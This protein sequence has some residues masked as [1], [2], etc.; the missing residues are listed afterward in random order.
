MVQLINKIRFLNGD[1]PLPHDH[2]LHKPISSWPYH[3][4]ATTMADIPAIRSLDVAHEQC[5]NFFDEAQIWRMDV[6]FRNLRTSRTIKSCRLRDEAISRSVELGHYQETDWTDLPIGCHGMNVFSTPESKARIRIVEESFLNDCFSTDPTIAAR[7]GTRQIPQVSYRTRLEIRNRLATAIYLWQFDFDAY[8]PSI[9][10]DP[11][12]HRRFVIKHKKRY[13][14]LRCLGTG[15]RWSVVVAQSIT[16]MI[17]DVDLGEDDAIG[18]FTIIDNILIYGNDLDR[19]IDVVKKIAS[20]ITTANLQSTP[21]AD[22]VIAMPRSE[23]ERIAIEP[24]VFCGEEYARDPA[25]PNRRMIRNST[26]TAA[27]MMLAIEQFCTG[28]QLMTPTKRQFT[29]LLSLISYAM[30]TLHV[31]PARYWS[32]FAAHRA[33]C[34]EATIEGWDTPTT[35]IAPTVRRELIE[36]VDMCANREFSHIPRPR[37]MATYDDTAY[38]LII[39]SDAS[40]EGWGAYIVW[41][42]RI[43]T[44]QR[45][46]A[47]TLRSDAGPMANDLRRIFNPRASPD[48]EPSAIKF[49]LRSIPHFERDMLQEGV[50]IASVTDHHAIPAAQRKGNGFGGIG[51]GRFLNDMYRETEALDRNLQIQIDHFF[52]EGVLNAADPLSRNL[53]DECEE[54]VWREVTSTIGQQLPQLGSLYCPLIHDDEIREPWMR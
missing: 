26:K 40:A 2:L 1:E 13:F 12:C 49:I 16:Y 6:P 17:V 10:T 18:I 30:H 3:L 42:N 9:P 35:Y 33:V 27:K 45:R 11:S 52:V 39:H 15:A 5:R 32:L 20:R 43:F 46:W 50:R 41:R 36:L 7:L 24:T 23:I 53:G 22:A 51:H 34:R 4:K 14:V 28:R 37:H 8:Y 48:T 29:A 54:I 21:R 47:S 19:F 38:D 31:S 44:I 25:N